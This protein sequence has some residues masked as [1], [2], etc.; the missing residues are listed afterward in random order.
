[1]ELLCCIAQHFT[2]EFSD[3][4]RQKGNPAALLHRLRADISSFMQRP[5]DNTE[6]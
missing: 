1:M 5:M 4:P 6:V 3:A 2:P